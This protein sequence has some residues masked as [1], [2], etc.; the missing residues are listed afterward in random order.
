MK[1]KLKFVNNLLKTLLRRKT[2]AYC[3][4]CFSPVWDT[5]WMGLVKLE[6]NKMVDD[7]VTW[8]LNKEIKSAGDWAF[9]KKNVKAGGWAFQFNNPHYP[10]VDDTALVGMFLDRYNRTK[11]NKSVALSIE[12]TR[13]WI[14][15]CN[16]KMVDG[17]HLTLIIKITHLI[18]FLLLIME[19]Y[20]TRP[21]QMFQQDV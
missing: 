7:L 6:Q 13:K 11:N 21:Q 19:H 18:L 4:P 2:V 1:S 8:F 20:L 15:Q 12:R 9:N 17:V 16:Q 10:D 5:G 14:F 3:Q